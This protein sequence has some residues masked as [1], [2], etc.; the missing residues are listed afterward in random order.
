VTSDTG[1]LF[2]ERLLGD[3]DD[4]VLTSL[5]HFGDELRA[6]RGAGTSALIAAIVPGAAGTAGAAFEASTGAS[7]ARRAAGAST[8][9]A[10]T[11]TTTITAATI[12]ATVASAAATAEGPLKARTR[13][14]AADARGIARREIF[15]WGVGAARRARF[16]RQEDDVVF[17]HSGLHSLFAGGCFDR[18]VFVIVHAVAVF[19]DVGCGAFAAAG[20]VFGVVVSG[21][22]F[23]VGAFLRS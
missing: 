14:A 20:V 4:D 1:A 21:V 18:F 5:E 17:D 16:T 13:I 15:T 8:A 22:G 19:V 3:L 23:G 10:A 11:I 12:A 6:A 2:A 7:A 9:I